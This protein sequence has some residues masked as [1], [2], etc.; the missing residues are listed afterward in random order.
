MAHVPSLAL[1]DGVLY[2]AEAALPNV[3]TGPR[4]PVVWALRAADVVTDRRVLAGRHLE[5]VHAAALVA[6]PAGAALGHAVLVESRDPG[7]AGAAVE[8][9][10]AHFAG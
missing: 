2:S 7:P 6:L 4:V 5:R 10:V 9:V 8:V 3:I 1:P